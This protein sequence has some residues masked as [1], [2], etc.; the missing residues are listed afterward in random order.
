MRRFLGLAARH[1]WA[2]ALV[3]ACAIVG[4]SSVPLPAVGP[5]LFPGCDKI[6]HLIEYFI[7]GVALCYW[8]PGPALGGG[9]EPASQARETI[10]ESVPEAAP[11]PG[12][13]SQGRAGLLKRGW[14]ILG[15]LVF[16]GADEVHQGF[17][18]GRELSLG[19]FLADA[20]GLSLG[21]A[22][23]ARLISKILPRR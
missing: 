5:E 1:R 2:P 4:V 9:A 18:P 8:V 12:P 21:Y 14:V 11:V 22:L 15:G 20:A 17:V 3:W 19:D 6:A 23:G 10:P 16:A 13:G 7:L